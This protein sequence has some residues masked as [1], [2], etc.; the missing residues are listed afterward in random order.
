MMFPYGLLDWLQ[1]QTF[2]N[3]LTH[4]VKITI[5]VVVRSALMGKLVEEA[6]KLLEDM[7]SKNI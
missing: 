1:V 7:T 2:Y 4:L 3:D 6:Y 5:D